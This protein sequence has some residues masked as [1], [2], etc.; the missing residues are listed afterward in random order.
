MTEPRAPRPRREPVQERSRERVRRIV[1]AAAELFA[2]Q[3]FEATTTDAIAARAGTSIG[4]LYQFFPHKGAVFDVLVTRCQEEMQGRFDRVLAEG[5]APGAPLPTWDELLDRMLAALAAIF[6]GN[7]AFRALWT[8]AGVSGPV[9][10]ATQRA[11]AEMADRVA[12]ALAFYA[13]DLEGS[14]R[15]VVAA[16]LVEVASMMLLLSVQR[17][18]VFGDEVMVETRRLLSRYMRPYLTPGVG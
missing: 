14:R 2:E 3:G 8:G 1:D 6:R 5:L 9:L 11:H 13:P 15:T 16:V 4:S 12:A 10:E 7:P 17:D 18:E